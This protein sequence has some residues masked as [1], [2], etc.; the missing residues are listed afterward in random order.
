MHYSIEPVAR[1]FFGAHNTSLSKGPDLRFG[2]KGSKS[3]NVDKNSFYDHESCL[4]GGV[5][6]LIMQENSFANRAQ[7]REWYKINIENIS[8]SQHVPQPSK[9]HKKSNIKPFNSTFLYATKIY[10]EANNED[11]FVASHP[12]AA[13]KKICW[14]A[15]ASRHKAS[16]SL[17][18][19]NQD[20]IIVPMRDWNGTLSGV[21]CINETGKKQTFGKKGVL[22][23]GNDLDSS[24]P[25]LVV[26]GWA[27]GVA[28][29]KIYEGNIAVYIA[30][31]KARLDLVSDSLD[32]LYPNRKIVI[33]RESDN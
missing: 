20:C 24:L 17:I 6:D 5:L 13:K 11:E 9:L 4:G 10:Q 32:E 21:E 27:T 23:L 28:F 14:S 22:I 18:G 29:F 25:Q 1:Y 15:G 19:K 3:I 16:G 12:Y 7:A 30:F 31:G 2:K 8:S 26:E 33:C